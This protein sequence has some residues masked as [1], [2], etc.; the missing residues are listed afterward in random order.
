MGLRDPWEA[1]ATVGPGPIRAS[2]T[3]FLGRTDDLSRA[4]WREA[5]GA[6]PGAAAMLHAAVARDAGDGWPARLA[7]RWL[8][9]LFGAGTRGLALALPVLPRTL[10]AS[11]FARA[12]AL[13]GYAFRVASAQGT[14]P[15]ALAS[16]PWFVGAHRLAFVFGALAADPEFGVR[17]LG[18]GRRIA[19]RQARILA[20]TALLEARVGAARVVL[21]G[22]ESTSLGDFGGIGE[23]LF[24]APLDRRFHGVWPAPRADEQARWLALLLAPAL[25]GALREG[26]DADWFRNPRAWAHLRSQGAG[27]AFEAVDETSLEPGSDALVACFERAL[28]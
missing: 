13:F 14:M 21:G 10:G 1:A 26:F 16:D 19:D 9:E 11:S 20:R 7:P 5:L 15:F 17:S 4:I 25:R 27:P 18:L 6:E 2:A 8:E 28:G 12:L 23:R 22:E 24:G 3:R